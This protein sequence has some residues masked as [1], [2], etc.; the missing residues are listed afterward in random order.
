MPRPKLPENKLASHVIALRCTGAEKV[1][2]ERA[3]K[4]AGLHTA[5]F[6]KRELLGA[7]TK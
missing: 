2:I 1:R 5:T 6:A 3:A 7:I 4:R